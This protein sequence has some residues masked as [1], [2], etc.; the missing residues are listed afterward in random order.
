MSRSIQQLQTNAKIMAKYRTLILLRLLTQPLRFLLNRNAYVYVQRTGRIPGLSTHWLYVY[1]HGLGIQHT[2][3]QAYGLIIAFIFDGIYQ[4][5]K[6]PFLLN[7][8]ALCY[9][10]FNCIINNSYRSIKLSSI[11]NWSKFRIL[12]KNAK[13]LRFPIIFHN[14]KLVI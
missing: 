9:Y 6:L 14:R 3:I 7:L 8:L 2:N 1:V 13:S 10:L 12:R 4:L 11:I 5:M